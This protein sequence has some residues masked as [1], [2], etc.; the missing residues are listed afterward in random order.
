MNKLKQ[1]YIFVKD[2]DKLKYILLLISSMGVYLYYSI[3]YIFIYEKDNTLFNFFNI[4][5]FILIISIIIF[6]H[7]KI[8]Y[9]NR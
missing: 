8:Y 3:P 4:S 5:F 1:S 2:D 9:Q 7:Y 6:G